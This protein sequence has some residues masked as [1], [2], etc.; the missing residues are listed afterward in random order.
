MLVVCPDCGAT[1]QEAGKYC[2]NCGRLLD[3]VAPTPDAGGA[4]PA[5]LDGAAPAAPAPP[6]PPDTADTSAPTPTASASASA[7]AGAGAAASSVAAP[8]F[9]AQFAVVRGDQANP[10]DGFTITL[11]GEFLVGRLDTET[12]S[13]VDIDLRQWVKPMDVDGRQQYLIHR[14]QCYLGLTP[15]GAAMVR[16]CPGAELDTLVR[17]AGG[18]DYVPLQQFATVRAALPGSDSIPGYPLQPGDRLYM[19]DPEA[20]HEVNNPKA[21]D[22]YLIVELL[23]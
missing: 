9:K 13:P 3:N 20:L 19:G 6:P 17:P 12:G 15:D 16:A 22:T 21:Q 4:Q 14:H 2:E 1:G 5:S 23:P 18:T 10:D 7:Q 11:P 8:A